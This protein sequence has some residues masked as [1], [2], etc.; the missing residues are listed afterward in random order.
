MTA[1]MAR[2][3]PLKAANKG[4]LRIEKI[5]N[6]IEKGKPPME[7]PHKDEWP[8]LKSSTGSK[9]GKSGRKQLK[10]Q[11]ILAKPPMDQEW[12]VKRTLP[13]EPAVKELIIENKL[14]TQDMD[15]GVE[16]KELQ[17]DRQP[18]RRK[19]AAKGLTKYG[20]K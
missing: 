17:T 13:A 2:G 8:D 12:K 15:E 20:D 19:D 11:T 10:H 6:N 5:R 7:I 4:K 14:E 18:D 1:E 16:T 9:R 3:H